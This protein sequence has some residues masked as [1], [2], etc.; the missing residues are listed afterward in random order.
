MP[1]APLRPAHI[2]DRALAGV[3]VLFVRGAGVRAVGVIGFFVLAHL[4]SPAEYG[5]VAIGI[6]AVLLG[7]L[8][9]D[10]GLGAFYI[11]RAE[12]PTREEL[13]AVTGA[14]LSVGCALVVLAIVLTPFT[15][16]IGMLT[17][18]MLTG[19][20]LGTLKLQGAV[21]LE[22]ELTF[23]PF[24]AVD[25]IEILVYYGWA[26]ASAA[27]GLG[28]VALAAAVP[29]RAVTGTVA[30]IRLSGVSPIAPSLRLGG[31]REALAYGA[32][33]QLGGLTNLGRDQALNGLTAAFG[34]LQMLGLWSVAARYIATP[35]LLIEALLTASVPALARLTEIGRAA[36]PLVERTIALTAA[37]AGLVAVMLFATAPAAVPALLGERW[38]DI[39]PLLAFAGVGLVVATPVS[40]ACLAYLWAVGDA[41]APL[42]AALWHSVTGLAVS[43]ALLPILGLTA[44]GVGMLV[45]SLTD[46]F[47]VAR[48]ARRR[49]ELTI[50]RHVA[51]PAAACLL[52][53]AASWEIA[54]TAVSPVV[55]LV[56]STGAGTALYLTILMILDRTLVSEIV[57]MF[58]VAA[59]DAFRPTEEL[60]D[61]A[62]PVS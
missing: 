37:A 16:E 20:P 49:F 23:R 60:R 56:L 11:R 17:A 18:V 9:V 50:L 2:R 54:G 5:K 57:R 6:A 27:S 36:R 53:G 55:A 39:I 45:M 1:A 4:L 46:A 40:I 24:V 26:I 43:A 3:V 12:A 52:A 8:F 51:A 10:A 41:K 47:V 7:N 58:R 33:Q 62:A 61:D 15:G 35:S 48:A 31:T 14:Q 32:R 42:R 25:L 30:M 13:A 22:R 19:L 21:A 38:E 34:G 28:L 59:R 29:L 44:L